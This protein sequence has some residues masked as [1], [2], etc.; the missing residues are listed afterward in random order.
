MMHR[1]AG[2]LPLL[3]AIPLLASVPPSAWVPARWDGTNPKTLDLLSGTPINCLLLNTYTA[4]FID[5]ASARG[6]AVLAVLR[7]G[8]DPSDAARKAIHAGLQGIVLEGDFPRGAATRVRDALA[9][10]HATVVELTSRARM[11]LGDPDPIVATYQGVWPGIQVLD[12]GA[13]KAAPSGSPWIDTNTGFIRSVRAWGPA[14][15]WLGYQP[16]ANSVI[17][18]E[19]YLAA[20]SDA[21][22]AGARWI[23]A[24][25]GDLS[26]RLQRGDAD[27]V[28]VW[29]AMAQVLQFFETHPEWRT[30][31]SYGKLAVVQ[32]KDDAMLSGG[33]LDMIAAKHTPL[34]AIPGQRLTADSL[35]GASMAVNVDADALTVEQR[36]ILKSFA[37]AGG[38]VLTAPP[39]WKG[40]SALAP[41]QITLDKAE[42]DR[43]NDIW[44]DVQTMTGRKNL[45]ARLFNVASM[46]SNVLATEDRGQVVV[47][48]VNY[49][50]YPIENVTVQVVGTFRHA[51]L[52]TPGGAEKDLEVYTTDEGG[53]GVDIERVSA[54]ATVRLD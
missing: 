23:V 35:A 50:A 20:I 15:V 28:K 16:P 45:G 6:V 49:S 1:M 52:I 54:C 53:T 2:C 18:I 38:T 37:R 13:A 42:L 33:I 19:R 46:L 34:R 3:T 31:R 26:A 24:L 9:D 32:D 48:L 29:R 40:Q 25:D 36:E 41:D 8:G 22:M 27:A 12:N 11:P 4:E 10:A 7:P 44:H 17:T 14:A 21:E 5:R 47:E 43:L 30:L 51:R 39:G